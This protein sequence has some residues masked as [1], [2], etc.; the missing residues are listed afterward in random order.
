MYRQAAIQSANMPTE[1]DKKVKELSGISEYQRL[2][3]LSPD[4]IKMVKIVTQRI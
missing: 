3:K 4:E 1:K 2:K